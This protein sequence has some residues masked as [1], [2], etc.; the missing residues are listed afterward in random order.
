MSRSSRGLVM[1]LGLFVA[2]CLDPL[3]QDGDP[4]TQSWV[5]CC[6]R[7]AIDTCFCEDETSC[8][9]PIF[10][11]AGGTCATNP[12][13]FVSTSD[14]GT[15]GG[16]GSTGGG[17]GGGG[18]VILDGGPVGGGA[19]QDAGA[20]GG[21]GNSSYDAGTGGGT[22]MSTGF[23]FCCV[24]SRVTTCAC[25]VSGCIGAPFTPCPGGGCVAGTTQAICR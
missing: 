17:S 5:V 2:A 15:G 19:S 7:G 25:G 14:A 6:Q 12:Q 10:A 13:C 3:Y 1:T 21:G 23:E 4:L 9:Q 22:T 8:M 20:G 11:C 16:S 18:A 24:N